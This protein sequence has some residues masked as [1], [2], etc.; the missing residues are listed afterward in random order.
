MIIFHRGARGCAEAYAEE[1][2]R[3]TYGFEYLLLSRVLILFI[4]GSIPAERNYLRIASWFG[5]CR[6]R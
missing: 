3:E 6:K 2:L 5:R 1:Y 4:A